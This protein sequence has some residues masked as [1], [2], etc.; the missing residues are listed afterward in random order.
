MSKFMEDKRPAD[1]EMVPDKYFATPDS[2]KD[3]ETYLNRFVGNERMAATVAAGMT[4]NLCCK[5]AKEGK[6]G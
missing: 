4:W 2:M 3:L 5:L 6:V 1:N